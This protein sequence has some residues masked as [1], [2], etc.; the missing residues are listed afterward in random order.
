MYETAR[1]VMLHLLAE[2]GV[3][4]CELYPQTFSYILF[5]MKSIS[6][7]SVLVADTRPVD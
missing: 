7:L 5:S 3:E 1:G 4:W 6:V 2:Q